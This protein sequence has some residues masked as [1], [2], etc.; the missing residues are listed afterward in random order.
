[1]IVAE[2]DGKVLGFVAVT[3]YP[4]F[5]VEEAVVLG[6]V[7]DEMARNDGVGAELLRAAEAWAWNGGARTIAVRSNVVRADAHR[8]YERE[9]YRRKK[10]QHIFEKRR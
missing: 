10:S 7:V 2:R 1:M 8:F 4:E 9:G 3:T 6:L 5:I